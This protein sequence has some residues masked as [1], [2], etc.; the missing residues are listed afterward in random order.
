M[1]MARQNDIEV[2]RVPRWVNFGV[3][4]EQTN[5]YESHFSWRAKGKKM[6]ERERDTTYDGRFIYL[7]YN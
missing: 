3:T 5:K 2:G 1:D 7:F 6:K 4:N